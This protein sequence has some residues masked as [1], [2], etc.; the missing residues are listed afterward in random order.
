MNF[1]RNIK[2]RNR[3]LA[4]MT[5]VILI[6]LGGGWAYAERQDLRDGY[7]RWRQGPLPPA[8]TAAEM[9][10]GGADLPPDDAGPLPAIE[11]AAAP[12]TTSESQDTSGREADPAADAPETDTAP[13]RPPLETAPAAPVTLP[14]EINLKVPMVYQAPLSNWDAQHEDTCEEASMLMVQAFLGGET[15]LTREEMEKRIQDLV[16]DEQELLGFFESTDA[17]DTVQVM[18]DALGMSGAKILPVDSIDDV[19]RQLA[20]GHPV[21]LPASG[22]ALKNPNF[23]NGGP[24]YHMLVAKGYTASRIITNDPGTRKGADYLY[25]PGVLFQAIHDWN[26]GDVP[27]GAKIMIVVGRSES[28]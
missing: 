13:E 6:V 17:Q 12:E 20:A 3:R 16:S 5:A 7:Q 23:R 19:K 18:I 10:G 14:D 22:K 27:N 25:D 1:R 21:M 26:G 11:E 28:P 24:L 2:P 9:R 15:S 8:L 4:A